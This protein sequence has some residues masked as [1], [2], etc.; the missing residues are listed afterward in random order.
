ML[1]LA[2]EADQFVTNTL[3]ELS[4]TASTSPARLAYIPTAP[5]AVAT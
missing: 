3:G 4:P 5:S 2:A 1:P